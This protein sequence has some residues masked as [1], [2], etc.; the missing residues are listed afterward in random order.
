MSIAGYV[1]PVIVENLTTLKKK[2]NNNSYFTI[3]HILV[4]YI[5]SQ[6][7]MPAIL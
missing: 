6:T 5:H 1:D 3:R 2:I 7:I 4:L